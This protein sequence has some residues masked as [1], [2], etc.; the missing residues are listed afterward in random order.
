MNQTAAADLLFFSNKFSTHV[1]H[2]QKG[3]N[4]Y[5]LCFFVVC[6]PVSKISREPLDRFQ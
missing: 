1:T 3:E 6:L 2:V 4:V 5:S